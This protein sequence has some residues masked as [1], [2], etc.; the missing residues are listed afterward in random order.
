MFKTIYFYM[1]LSMSAIA[2]S[3]TIEITPS[4]KRVDGGEFSSSDVSHHRIGV[5]N[6]MS[7]QVYDFICQYKGPPNICEIN[8]PLENFYVFTITTVMND[9]ST[10][11]PLI[12]TIIYYGDN[13]TSPTFIG[14]SLTPDITNVTKHI[15]T[16]KIAPNCNVVN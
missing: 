5:K 13:V 3:Y 16:C 6:H 4:F 10:S 7:G 12:S 11:N 2:Y 15:N 9:G 14:L 1:L 8:I